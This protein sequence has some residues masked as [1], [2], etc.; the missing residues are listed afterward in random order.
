MDAKQNKIVAVFVFVFV[1]GCLAA[2]LVFVGCFLV[3][4]FVLVCSCLCLEH[5]GLPFFFLGVSTGSVLAIYCVYSMVYVCVF[6]RLRCCRYYM[7]Y[8]VFVPLESGRYIELLYY[9]G[10]HDHSVLA[11]RFPLSPVGAGGGLFGQIYM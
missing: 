1:L 6:F 4:L 7:Q 5:E 10:M 8:K 11:W 9:K 3:C 2:G